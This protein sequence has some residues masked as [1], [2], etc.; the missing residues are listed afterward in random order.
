MDMST[1]PAEPAS[2]ADRP[3]VVPLPPAPPLLHD[4]PQRQRADPDPPHHQLDRPRR[5]VGRGTGSGGVELQEPCSLSL[6]MATPF[7]HQ[8]FRRRTTDFARFNEII[9]VRARCFGVA[10]FTG[11]PAAVIAAKSSRVVIGRPA[12]RNRLM[13][14]SAYVPPVRTSSTP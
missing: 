7:S 11:L 1:G 14:T 6:D 3:P 12:V 13:A 4:R 8:P 9:S 2:Q 5:V 10:P